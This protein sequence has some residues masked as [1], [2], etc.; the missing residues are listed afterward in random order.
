MSIKTF[1]S[2]H[3]N[4]NVMYRQPP[5]PEVDAAWQRLTMVDLELVAVSGE[6]IAKSGKDPSVAVPYGDTPDTYLA[7]LDIIHQ[8]HCLNTL[9]QHIHYDYYWSE[10]IDENTE[11][12][13][14]HCLHTLLQ[15]HHVQGRSINSPTQ[16]D[17]QYQGDSSTQGRLSG[18]EEMHRL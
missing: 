11:G 16:L 10:P 1:T 15:N 7:E 2:H 18:D 3:Y 14:D 13:R 17:E 8:L 12:H 6:D 4:K 5:S 9:R